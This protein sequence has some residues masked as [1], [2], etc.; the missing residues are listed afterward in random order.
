[1]K[2]IITILII[3][4]IKARFTAHRACRTPLVLL[5]L[6]RF[7]QTITNDVNLGNFNTGWKLKLSVS[8]H[9][10]TMHTV[11]GGERRFVVGWRR[12]LNAQKNKYSERTKYIQHEQKHS[13]RFISSLV[14][15]LHRSEPVN[16]GWIFG[17]Y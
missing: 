14:R 11:H 15:R 7:R 5:L 2:K 9:Q 4:K 16:D 13:A 10:L 3:V 6:Q 12:I 17:V 8:A 1:V